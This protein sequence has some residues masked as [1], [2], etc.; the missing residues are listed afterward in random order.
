[1]GQ[2]FLKLVCAGKDRL[3]QGIWQI[4]GQNSESPVGVVP[5]RAQLLQ[6]FGSPG[7]KLTRE[8]ATIKSDRTFLQLPL[9]RGD[10]IGRVGVC[11][12]LAL[13]FQEWKQGQIYLA[14]KNVSDNFLDLFENIV[15]RDEWMEFDIRFRFQCPK[16]FA[17]AIRTFSSSSFTSDPQYGQ[18]TIFFSIFSPWFLIPSC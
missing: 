5:L 4:F 14:P 10:W 2:L 7:V 11:E 17:V 6:G 1:L 9:K 3:I 12:S 8:P 18:L 13:L 16:S 15:G